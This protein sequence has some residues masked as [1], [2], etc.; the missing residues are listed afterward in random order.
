MMENA[1]HR[2][3][4]QLFTFLVNHIYKMTLQKTNLVGIFTA[5]SKVAFKQFIKMQSFELIQEN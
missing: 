1:T 3:Y 4:T 2:L 5:P